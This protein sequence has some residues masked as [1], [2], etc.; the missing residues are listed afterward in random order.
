MFNNLVNCF[1]VFIN[2]FVYI[3]IPLQIEFSATEFKSDFT[4]SYRK[5]AHTA[6]SSSQVLL[7]KKDEEDKKKNR[8]GFLHCV[9]RRLKNN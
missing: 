6:F 5:Q 9:S 1:Y 4:I 7:K 2:N 3:F 8:N